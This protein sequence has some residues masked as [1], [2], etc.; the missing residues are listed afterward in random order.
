MNFQLFHT[1]DEFLRS[2]DWEVLGPLGNCLQGFAGVITLVT[3]IFLLRETKEITNQTRLTSS[4]LMSGIYQE[5]A[6][7]MIQID[8]QFVQFPELRPYFY[9]SRPIPRGNR[10]EKKLEH[11][12]AMAEMIIDFMDLLMVLKNIASKS[13]ADQEMRLPL[14]EWTTYFCE[15]Y[16]TSPIMQHY[17]SEHPHWYNPGLVTLLDDCLQNPQP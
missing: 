1:I 8:S 3:I 11:I 9:G 15:L 6:A 4:S 5:I 12:T 2:F 10:N 17:L 14:D 7:K 16:R 13:R